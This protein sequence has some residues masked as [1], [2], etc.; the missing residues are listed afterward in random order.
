[1]TAEAIDRACKHPPADTRA[2]TRGATIALWSASKRHAA[3]RCEWN[4]ITDPGTQEV[5]NVPDPFDPSDVPPQRWEMSHDGADQLFDRAISLYRTSRF[6]AAWRLLERLCNA[7]PWPDASPRQV[8]SQPFRC[9]RYAAW[10]AARLGRADA[11]NHLRMIHGETIDASSMLKVADHLYVYRFMGLAP[12]PRTAEWVESAE[13]LMKRDPP[14]DE[15]LGAAVRE[16]VG[17]WH[18][19]H[20]RL[21]Q[22]EDAIGPAAHEECTWRRAR[23]QALLAE[24]Y[25]RRGETDRARKTLADVARQIPPST[26]DVLIAEQITPMRAR[27]AD[28]PIE[29]KQL[30]DQAARVLLRA[31]HPMALARV[32]VLKAREAC[33]DDAA[34]LITIRSRLNRLARVAVSLG[35]CELTRSLLS[36]WDEWCSAACGQS[37]L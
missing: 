11:V 31:R 4:R 22:V 13:E 1:V 36:R 14:A 16:H 24:L 32:L 5:V 18:L 7:N 12:H 10:V 25:R 35:Q 21:D 15:P 6:A 19:H 26:F 29:R 23:I 27:L 3:A 28:D 17:A 9:F 8:G 20:G 33:G 2:R 37:V 30:Y 34:A